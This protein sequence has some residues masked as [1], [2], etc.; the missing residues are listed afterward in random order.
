M[1]PKKISTTWT[2]ATSRKTHHQ[3]W[4][5]SSL[6]RNLK[7]N[8]KL[9][10]R[11]SQKLL[12]NHWEPATIPL[13]DPSTPHTTIF[14]TTHYST[15]SITLTTISHI[16]S[17]TISSTNITT[18]INTPKLVKTFLPTIPTTTFLGPVTLPKQPPSKKKTSIKES[19]HI[20]ISK[21][22]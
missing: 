4:H 3:P 15:P 18:S 11:S 17:L 10:G 8:G 16:H 20:T 9:C 19:A 1:I 22:D 7:K 14:S 13:I 6:R 2:S 5:H 12:D 21:T